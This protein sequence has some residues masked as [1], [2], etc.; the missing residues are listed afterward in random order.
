VRATAFAA[1]LLAA[2]AAPAQA[3][4]VFTITFEDQPS[5]AFVSNPLVYPEATFT[6]LGDGNFIQ[7]F[8]DNVLCPFVGAACNGDLQI[9]IGAAPF[10]FGLNL[11]FEIA[12]DEAPGDIGD[13]QI[14]RDGV[15][16]ATTDLIADGDVTTR[17]FVD[18]TS[19]GEFNRI[20]ITTTDSLGLYYDNFSF[21]II[22]VDPIPAPAA[23]A[24]F[25]LGLA[26]LGVARRRG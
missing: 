6:S 15:L 20:I 1:L 23:L 9:D 25:G 4:G 22:A 8:G 3:A 5:L 10:F 19:F 7:V 17:D 13:I 16:V 14:F 2:A 12:A 11:S 24:L 21:D 18:L 26:G